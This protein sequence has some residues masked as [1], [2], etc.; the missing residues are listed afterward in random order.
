MSATNPNEKRTII[1]WR[2][3]HEHAGMI[4]DELTNRLDHALPQG[5]TIIGDEMR[6][7][8]RVAY[9]LRVNGYRFDARD[10]E[11]VLSL[12]MEL[13]ARVES[14]LAAFAELDAWV[15]SWHDDEKG[16]ENA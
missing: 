16:A 1:E 3:G 6:A 11:A 4:V 7:A 8:L 15:E 14:E 5:Q 9:A 13:L 2:Q 10:D 12:V